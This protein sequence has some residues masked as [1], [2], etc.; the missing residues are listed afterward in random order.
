M[1]V[2]DL[3]TQQLLKELEKAVEEL[4][5]ELDNDKK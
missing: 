5:K 2:L 4:E 1:K 3:Y